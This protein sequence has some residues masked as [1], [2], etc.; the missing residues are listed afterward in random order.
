[1][2]PNRNM[3][4]RAL[5]GWGSDRWSAEIRETMQAAARI[6]PDDDVKSRFERVIEGGAYDDAVEGTSSD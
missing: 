1:M 5:A 3:A 6:E 4:L 2:I